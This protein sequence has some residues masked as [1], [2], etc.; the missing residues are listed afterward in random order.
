MTATATRSSSR[1]GVTP[2]THAGDFEARHWA[3][4][5]LVSAIFGSAFL[6]IALALE[7]LA[8]QVVAAG[9]V[10]L[11][12]GALAAVP[13]ARRR[14]GRAD[15]GKVVAAGVFG[16]ALPAL[17]FALAEQR[18]ASATT[19]MLVSA[20][21][22]VIAALTAILSRTLPRRRRMIGLALG[23]SGVVLLAAPDVSGGGQSV[24]GIG[25]VLVAVISYAIA[26]IIY[27]PLQQRYGSLP[28]VLWSLVVAT[29]A[30]APLGVAGLSSSRF[31]TGPVAALVIL[32]VLGTG[33]VRSLHVAL[34]GRVGATRASIVA[35]LVPVVALGLGVVVLGEHIR[36]IQ[37]AG[38]AVTSLGGYLVSKRT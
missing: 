11:G 37:L 34:V 33:V 5:V 31:E 28:V 36:V 15:M 4:L 12:A 32:G 13:A 24:V 22:V 7:S 21:P 18:I 2:G 25:L 3:H 16:Q 27:V 9:R 30:L 29:V 10:T 19:G 6:W 38:I 1:R 14:I 20:L 17:L 35:W 8:P 23:M 26:N